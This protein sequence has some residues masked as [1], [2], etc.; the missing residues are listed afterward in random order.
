[1]SFPPVR[2]RH[3]GRSTGGRPARVAGRSRPPSPEAGFENG[4]EGLLTP[5]ERPGGV[6]VRPATGVPASAG[7]GEW[8]SLRGRGHRSE[9]AGDVTGRLMLSTEWT[10]SAVRIML[11]P[12]TVRTPGAWPS[13]SHAHVGPRTVSISMSSPTSWASR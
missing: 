8:R 11:P 3:P 10:T 13:S 7:E 12:A 6:R 2:S 9:P 4:F 1:M 5:K